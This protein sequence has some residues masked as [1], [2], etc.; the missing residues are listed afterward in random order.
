MRK[1]YLV[2]H[3]EIKREKGE[4]KCL[5]Q[6]DVPLAD[7]AIPSSKELG[8]WFC[9]NQ[10]GRKNSLLL[11]SGTLIR[12]YQTAEYIR[13]GAGDS[14]AGK[15]IL[16]SDFNEVYT[17][18]WENHEFSEI[19]IYDQKRFEER[20]KSLG[21]FRF[22]E[23]ESIYDA[24]VR[25]ER[26]LNRLRQEKK[27]DIVIVSHSG[28]IRSFL[29]KMMGIPLDEYMK[30]GAANLS[31]T[32]L[33]D[34]GKKLLI[35]KCGYKSTSLLS[36]NEIED[37]YQKYNVPKP[38]IAHMKKTAEVVKQLKLYMNQPEF[39]WELVEK[40]AMLHDILRLEKFHALKGADILRR[41]GYYEIAELV[42]KH[43]TTEVQENEPITESELLFYADARVKED[44]FVSVEER[45]QTSAGKCH[46]MEARKKHDALYRKAKIIEKKIVGGE[47]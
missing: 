36:S 19:K 11:A 43:H 16:D 25:F 17:G 38:V 30:L 23:G 44:N 8:K 2:R 39:D 4:R 33:L 41:E 20:G 1:I 32:I 47:G 35:E 31:T 34:D 7:R 15:L 40:A 10:E 37:L 45:Y 29:C 42:E 18:L 3:G 9:K 28:T 22:P 14:I 24:G 12:A 27:E 13:D 46:S 21:F 6:T 5:G 26:A